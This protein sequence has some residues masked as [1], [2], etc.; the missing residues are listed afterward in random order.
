MNKDN[1]LHGF[2]TL[3]RV[4]ENGT[5]THCKVVTEYDEKLKELLENIISVSNIKGSANLQSIVNS[6]YI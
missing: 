3:D 5:T 6:S 4:L 1:K 2:I